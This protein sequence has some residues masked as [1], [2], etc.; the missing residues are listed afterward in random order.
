MLQKQA[1]E[2]FVSRQEDVRPAPQKLH[3]WKCCVCWGTRVCVCVPGTVSRTE[4]I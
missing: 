1:I 2:G 4:D 3:G